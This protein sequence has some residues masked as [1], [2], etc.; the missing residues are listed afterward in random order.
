[1]ANRAD[2]REAL[3]KEFA[4]LNIPIS[5]ITR[6]EATSYKGCPNTGCMQSHIKALRAASTYSNALILEDDFEFISDKDLIQT[7][8][9]YFF[10][11]CNN[12][13]AILLTTGNPQL[14]SIGHIFSPIKYSSNAAG[15]LMHNSA[16]NPLADLFEKNMENL[17][18]TKAHWI[19][20]N[21]Q[22]WCSLMEAGGWYMFNQYLGIQK[23]GYSDL[24]G[25]HKD[26]VTPIIIVQ[27]NV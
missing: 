2:R 8:L 19:Y 9:N 3:N 23:G 4:R 5:K 25:G 21:D 14:V 20:Q 27:T 16:C 1:M 22:L 18:I 17:Y 15:Y 7:S 12:W 24:S 26:D 11:N 6:I 13:S 10:T